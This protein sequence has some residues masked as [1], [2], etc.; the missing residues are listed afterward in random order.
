M[1]DENILDSDI[2]DVNQSIMESVEW[3]AVEGNG[4]T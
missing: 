4:I 2:F 3:W 1:K